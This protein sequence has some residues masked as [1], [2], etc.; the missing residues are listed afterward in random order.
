[1]EGNTPLDRKRRVVL[2]A[3]AGLPTVVSK[4]VEVHMPSTVAVPIEPMPH[5]IICQSKPLPEN[6][7]TTNE[8]PPSQ[9][10]CAQDE[11]KGGGTCKMEQRDTHRNGFQKLECEAKGAR[12]GGTATANQTGIRVGRWVWQVRTTRLGSLPKQFEP[13]MEL[14]Q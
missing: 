1:M 4:E 5:A 10:V 2:K 3:K 11:G 14:C 13:R 9:Q 6:E 8:R 7:T 12:D